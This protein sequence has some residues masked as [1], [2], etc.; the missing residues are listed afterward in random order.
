MSRRIFLALFYI[1][2]VGAVLEAAQYGPKEYEAVTEFK[3]ESPWKATFSVFE[4]GDYNLYLVANNLGS[5]EPVKVTVDGASVPSMRIPRARNRADQFCRVKLSSRVRLSAGSH[6][7]SIE[8]TAPDT[9]LC[10]KTLL[11]ERE[12]LPHNWT[13][14]WSEEFD[15]TEDGYPDYSKW[16]EE[17]GFLRNREEQYYL[18]HRKENL[19]IEDG[20][21]IITAIR[22]DCPNRF[23]DPNETKDW[24]KMRQKGV[25]TS[26]NL[27]TF[28]AWQYGTRVDVRFMVHSGK[29]VWP[30]AWMLG[31]C[32]KLGW[33]EG[34]EIDIMEYFGKPN[35]GYVTTVHMR[36]Q[37]TLQHI[38]PNE[39]SQ[40]LDGDIVDAFHVASAVWDEDKCVFYLDNVKTFEVL[41]SD[42]SKPWDLENPQYFKL[43]LAIGG[44]V[45][46]GVD[47]NLQKVE[48]VVDYVR[49]YQ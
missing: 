35:V 41:R 19:R 2:C 13:L 48:F 37:K 49:I 24:R 34:G 40:C 32:R 1:F 38:Q 29:G 23:F 20:K 9:K 16:W 22:E 14:V 6:D 18:T 15:D 10:V 28:D 31:E 11:V 42:K 5:N 12:T 25:F 7:I 43:N 27:N 33:P 26:G 47:P 39:H 46:D 21:L 30:A 8:A 45:F 44:S 17:E 3:G 4:N 36:D